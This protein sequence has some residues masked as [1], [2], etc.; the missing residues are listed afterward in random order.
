MNADD[1]PAGEAKREL[2]QLIR[3]QE[4]LL[5]QLDRIREELEAPGTAELIKEIRMRTGSAVAE[6]LGKVTAAVEEAIRQLKLSESAIRQ[7][8]LSEPG[9]ELHVEGVP[10]LP[11]A[12]ARFL[13][14][15]TKFPGFS[16]GVRQDAVRG[17]VISWKEH[18][19]D[20]TIR[21]F[22]Q[23]YERPYAWLDE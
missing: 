22:G 5:T 10:N 16:Y 20:G 2:A 7:E 13:A 12:L 6:G 4:R 9:G 1:A 3:M 15:R 14:E 19:E 8:L 23:F 17:W 18:T 21:G 11:P